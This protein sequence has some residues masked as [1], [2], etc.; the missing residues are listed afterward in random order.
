MLASYFVVALAISLALTPLC[1]AIAN[2]LGLVAKPIEDR[3]HRRPTAMVGGVAIVITVLGVAFSIEPRSSVVWQLM[4]CGA[5]I[6]AFGFVDD[7]VPL[8]ASTKLIAQ[9]TTASILVFFGYRLAWTQS[10]VFDVMLTLFWVVGVTNAFN[11]LDNMDGLCGGVTLIAGSFLLVGLWEEGAS[12]PA[13]LY[14]ASL[15]GATAGFLIYNLHPASIFMG[16]TGSLFL[17]LNL[18]TLT[19]VAMPTSRGRSGLV[20]VVIGPVLLLLIPIFDTALVTVMRLV[21]GRRPLQGG[22]DHSSHRLVAVGLSEPRA[23]SV[24]WT[25]AAAGGVISMLLRRHD[26]GMV[27]IVA[28]MFLIAM[29]LFA[30][31]LARIRVYDEDVALEKVTKETLTPLFVDFMYKRR[32]AEVLLDLCLIPLAYYTAYRLRFEGALLEANY[33]YFIQSL[34]VVL[35][36]QLLALFVMGGY[37]GTWRFFGLMDA[38]AFGKSVV[39]GT[40]AAELVILYLY[41]FQSYSRTVFVIYAAL[42]FLF[43]AGTRG[44]FRLAGEYVLR[45]RG[46]GRRCAIYGTG[47]A[48]LGTIREAFGTDVPMKILGYIDN[49]STHRGMRVEGY[50]VLG[51]HTDLLTMISRGDVDGV[52]LNTHLLDAKHLKELEGA[53]RDHGVELLHLQV[54]LRRRRAVS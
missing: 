3:W 14:L 25:L 38:I 12:I 17:G 33:Q 28:L 47:S 4:A 49:D 52:V 35:A 45:S 30:A 31:Y 26:A 54:H 37:R 32:V 7:V 1:R 16:D 29:G 19:L 11:L 50:T 9:V 20:S 18:A 36:T 48:S 41:R 53:C 24:L 6:A 10:M 34:P 13:A 15:L 2:R 51:N 21:S 23:V 5:L 8:K 27:L 42:M 44:S 40:V 46:V 39:V 43:L 22:R